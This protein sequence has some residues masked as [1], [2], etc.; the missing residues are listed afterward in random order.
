MSYETILFEVEGPTL[1][2]TLN[3]PD[4]HNCLNDK[5]VL[6]LESAFVK[7]QSENTIR[8]IIV[9]AKGRS[10]CAGA[11]LNDMKKMIKFTKEENIEESTHLSRLMEAVRGS[12]IPTL[13]V[14]QGPVYG[15]GCGL[16]ACCDVAVASPG[17]TFCF[18]EVKLGLI[19]AVISPYIWK[20]IGAGNMRRYF[21]TAEMI[22]A[23]EAR[24]IGLVHTVVQQDDLRV[25]VSRL[26]RHILNNGPEALEAA[27]KLVNT[28]EV[29]PYSEE[30][31]KYTIEAIAEI[32][33]S[34]EGQEGLNAFFEKRPA[35]W[36]GNQ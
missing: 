28:V 13:A 7:A 8:L 12:R 10:F 26:S 20:K 32:R 23:Y 11:D 36:R 16:V 34:N 29:D 4:V 21:I 22:D 33:V 35:S 24:R 2:I 5:M 18:S 1:T 19:P 15:G 9:K 27:K 17:V 14:V 3:R 30:T 31:R 6:E 25:E